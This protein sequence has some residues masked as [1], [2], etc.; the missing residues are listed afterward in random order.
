LLS[1]APRISAKPPHPDPLPAR[2]GEGVRVRHTFALT[3]FRFDL[4]IAEIV[5][6]GR[7]GGF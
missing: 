1:F 6:D 5:I 2:R 7:C 3:P 4:D